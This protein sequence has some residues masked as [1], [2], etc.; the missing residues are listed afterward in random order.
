[1][2][3]EIHSQRYHNHDR[4]VYVLHPSRE[5]LETRNRIMTRVLI[6]RLA[7]KPIRRDFCPKAKIEATCP[8]NKWVLS[9][10]TDAPVSTSWLELEANSFD[11]HMVQFAEP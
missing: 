1:M 9:C 2:A 10:A 7:N 3:R 6:Y 4:L 5:S 8:N 11:L